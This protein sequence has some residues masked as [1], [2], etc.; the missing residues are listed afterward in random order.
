MVKVVRKP[1]RLSA[2]AR[3][4]SMVGI[5]EEED[6]DNAQELD[7][8]LSL[9]RIRISHNHRKSCSPMDAVPFP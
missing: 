4:Y 5:T 9:G 3:G 8:V 6:G 1:C 2:A 7:E